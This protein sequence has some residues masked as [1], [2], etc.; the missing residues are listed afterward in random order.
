MC[1]QVSR[2]RLECSSL[3]LKFFLAMQGSLESF[4]DKVFK[5]SALVNPCRIAPVSHWPYPNIWLKKRL[6]FLLEPTN[7]DKF[8]GLSQQINASVTSGDLLFETCTRDTDG[9]NDDD[10]D[11]DDNDDDNNDDD[12]DDV[13]RNLWGNPFSCLKMT[14]RWKWFKL[15]L[16]HS[17]KWRP[18]KKPRVRIT[19]RMFSFPNKGFCMLTH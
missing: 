5:Q 2:P 12:D 17:L 13:E 15:H 9:S 19:P 8:S 16:T 7:D 3:K 6:L 14:F 4:C 10:N 1:L 18:D 11:D